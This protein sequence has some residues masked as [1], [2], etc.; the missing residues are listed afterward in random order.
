MKRRTS[1]SRD[2]IRGL[3]TDV[4]VSTIK[5]TFNSRFLL[6]KTCRKIPPLAKIADKLFF[7]DDCIQVLPRDSSIKSS[8]TTEEIEINTNIEIQNNKI[9]PS[10]I[11][12][13]MIRKSRYHFIM[14]SCICRV[15]NNCKNYP[16]DLGCLF[17]G[18][19]STRISTKLGKAVSK[20]EALEHVDKCQSAG[21][22]NIIGRNKIDSVWLNTGPKEE[23]LSIC[24]CCPCCCLWKMAP[25]LPEN[26][27]KGFM[28]MVGVEISYNED[29]CIGCGNCTNDICFVEARSLENKKAKIDIKKC[30]SC[31]RCVETCSKG[32]ITIKMENDAIKRSINRVDPLVN[33]KIE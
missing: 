9:L 20:E 22:V 12:K 10:E 32:A 7:E 4:T 1:I 2:T 16:H 8:S 3:Y 11:L 5:L 21:L 13:E 33:L 14:N 19:G 23:L 26:L 25:E 17:L 29:L 6:A 15:S 31:G 30:R 24:S 28:P 27:R 18:K